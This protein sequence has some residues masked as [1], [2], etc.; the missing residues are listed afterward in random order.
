VLEQ[1]G[2][3]VGQPPEGFELLLLG[4]GRFVID[5]PQEIKF[6]ADALR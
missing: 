1:P 2:H 6:R 5:D 4:I 3:V